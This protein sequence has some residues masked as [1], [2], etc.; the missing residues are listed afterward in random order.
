MDESTREV[1]NQ[2]Y[3]PIVDKA[4]ELIAAMT[5]LHGGFK[6]TSGFF[7]GHYHKNSAGSYYADAYPIP[8]I[9]VMGLCDIEIDFDGISLTTKLSKKQIQLFDWRVFG[10]IPFEVYVVENHLTDYGNHQSA[11]KI[12]ELTLS[13]AE[14]EFFVTL[15]LPIT[16]CGD[17]VMKLLERLQRNHFYY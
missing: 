6:T 9:S 7:N 2:F 10:E 15:S 3:H 4:H 8:V 11:D 12:S 16:A 14:K 1:L 5:R 13:S 17:K